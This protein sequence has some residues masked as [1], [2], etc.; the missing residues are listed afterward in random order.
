V[1]APAGRTTTARMP[2]SRFARGRA[3]AGCACAALALT[4]AGCTTAA[5]SSLIKGSTLSVYV[6]VPR[7]PLSIE[8][9]DVLAAEEL[10]FRQSGPACSSPPAGS[11]GCIQVGRLKVDLWLGPKNAR[12]LSDNA[13][14]AIGDS[15]TIAYVGEIAPGA[16]ADTIG[17][18]NAQDVLQVSPSDTAL[19]LTQ[20]IPAVPNSPTRY[21]E[22]LSTNGR[23]FARVVPT[24]AHEARFL[25][26]QMAAL[27]V[28]RVY[29][30]TD[31]SEYGK[32]LAY[33][34]TT[35]A[36][37]AIG[38]ASSASGAD[39]VLYAGSSQAGAATTFNGAAAANPGVKLF[40]ASAL[41]DQ[42]FVAS[43]APA[44]QRNA[45]FSSPGFSSSD[46]PPAAAQFGSSFKASYGHAPATEAIFGYE[47]VAAVLSVLK[48][49]GASAVNRSAVVHD[50]F[51]ISN[52]ASVLGTYSIDHN[53]D[54]SIAPFVLSRVRGG[55]LVPYRAVPAQG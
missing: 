49:A 19:E 21:Y 2:S 29:V 12:H 38:L 32:A 35:H 30:G 3:L 9:Q 48:T 46:L 18:T 43:L 44:A 55:K 23:T 22:S 42:T 31:G 8:A 20:A 17:I 4:V 15:T 5:S 41:A 11:A 26:A 50:F 37:P 51:A 1:A 10:A 34:I 27:G 16:S 39:A 36:S 24:D 54:T 25:I 52:R 47:A 14:Q 45:Y 40:G 28:K 6:S 7:G 53:G 13:R 33:A